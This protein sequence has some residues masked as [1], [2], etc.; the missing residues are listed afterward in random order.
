MRTISFGSLSWAMRRARDFDANRYMNWRYFCDYS[1][2]NVYENMCH[3]LSFW[4][5]ALKLA[6]S[7]GRSR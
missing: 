1:G 2:G 5:K 4:Y 7:Q 6:D 3:Q